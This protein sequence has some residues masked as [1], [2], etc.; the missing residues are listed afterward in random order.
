M[1][2][3]DKSQKKSGG[4]LEI[5]SVIVQ[6]LILAVIIRSLFFQPFSSGASAAPSLGL[7]GRYAGVRSCGLRASGH[8]RSR[9]LPCGS[10]SRIAHFIF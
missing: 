1:S 6:A 8:R 10:C 3:A 7:L 4:L 9:A 5:V 2:V